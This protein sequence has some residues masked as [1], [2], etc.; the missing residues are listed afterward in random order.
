MARQLALQSDRTLNKNGTRRYSR[1]E[2]GIIVVALTEDS[3]GTKRTRCGRYLRGAAIANGTNTMFLDRLRNQI[4]DQ[5]MKVCFIE[6]NDPL[7]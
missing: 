2:G 3:I 5:S 4:E 6:S 7:N 1:R